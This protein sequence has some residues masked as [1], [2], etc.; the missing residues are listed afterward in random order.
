MYMIVTIT[1]NGTARCA[2]I[3]GKEIPE[4]HT[5]PGEIAFLVEVLD[6]AAHH[7]HGYQHYQAQ[8]NLRGN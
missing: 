4:G 7:S 5:R 6:I 8:P 2:Q 1:A 3:M